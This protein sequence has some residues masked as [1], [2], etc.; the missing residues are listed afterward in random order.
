MNGETAKGAV[1]IVMFRH[2]KVS[3]SVG[4]VDGDPTISP[5]VVGLDDVGWTAAT[6]SSD[7]EHYL[8]WN[9]RT[10]D[11]IRQIDV[12]AFFHVQVV[13]ELDRLN[14]D[15]L[16][17]LIVVNQRVFLHASFDINDDNR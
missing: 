5:G 4:V 6:P 12:F 7:D 11:W 9:A 2:P 17:L 3:T 8:M 15:R 14:D 1:D 13:E 16:T 10:C